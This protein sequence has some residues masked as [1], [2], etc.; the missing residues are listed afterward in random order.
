MLYLILGRLVKFFN[1]V[2][3][4]SSAGRPMLIFNLNITLFAVHRER[5]EKQI[6][7]S[8]MESGRV[9]ELS[10]TLTEITKG[11]PLV[12]NNSPIL[13]QE[14]IMKKSTLQ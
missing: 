5:K 11:L 10:L 8:L 13:S 9:L 12:I 3:D 1:T 4:L 6:Y 7:I 14:L 2:F